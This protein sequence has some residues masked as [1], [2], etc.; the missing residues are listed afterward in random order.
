MNGRMSDAGIWDKCDL[1]QM[2]QNNSCNIPV[3][4][5]MPGTST[6][7][8]FHIVGDDAFPLGLH[9]LKPYSQA[10]VSGNTPNRVF[11]YR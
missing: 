10:L 5:N 1:K 11:N 7:V 4:S 6:P 2:L 8:D 9:L 3:A